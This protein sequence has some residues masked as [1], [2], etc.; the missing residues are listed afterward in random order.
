MRIRCTEVSVHY[1]SG[2]PSGQRSVE[3]VQDVSLDVAEGEFLSIVGPSG[4]GKSTLLRTLAGLIEPSRG[5]VERIS[6]EDPAARAYLVFQENSLFP[7]MTVL[8]NA[9]FG[10]KMLGVDFRSRRDAAVPLLERFGLAGRL[11]NYPHELS[12]GMK[13][14]VAV[15][16]AFISRPQ[17]LLMD[18]PFAALDWLSR[19][20]LQQDLL[21]LWREERKT[22]VFVTH[23]L[24]EAIRL[25]DRVVVMSPQPGRIVAEERIG[26]ERPRDDKVLIEPG[27]VAAKDRLLR[28][29]RASAAVQ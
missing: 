1:R 29:L 12:V 20:T 26:L 3:A 13:Q 22:V 9:A 2:H 14:R 27:F 7:W 5:T 17:A 23:D 4:C 25:S 16:R 19:M 15:A 18:E 24:E 8:D 6:E 11:A 21:E 10:L 28:A